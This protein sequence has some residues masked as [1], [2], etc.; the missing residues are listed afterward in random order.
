MNLSDVKATP[1]GRKPRTRKGRGRS[2]GKGKTCGRGHKGQRS[3]SGP[4]P[5]R[6]YE[7][8]QMPL[9]RRLPKRGFNNRRFATRYAVVNVRALDAFADGQEVG[10][11]QLAERGLIKKLHDG[12]KILGDGELN[13]RLTV[14]AHAFT[15]SAAHKIAEAGGEAVVLS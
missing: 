8:G 12:V 6:L 3:R 5:G 15:K 2:A 7:G 13:K 10:P 1:S 11:A 14:K 4:G 9:F